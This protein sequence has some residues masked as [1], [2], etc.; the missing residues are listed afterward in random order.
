[1]TPDE[2]IDLL[3][4][5]AS[6]DQRTIGETDIVA[7][8]Q[9]AT[10]CGWTWPLA[11]RAVLEHHKRGGDRPRIKPGHITDAIEAARAQIR[12]QVFQRDLVPPKELADNPRAE[13][14]W[15]RRHIAE[16]TE[17]A[18]NAWAN[19]QPLPQLEAEPNNEPR[20]DVE[21]VIGRVF[22][23]PRERP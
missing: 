16:V 18:L 4:L 12:R 15:R 11:R 22:E 1:M 5:I 3:T 8:H 21:G 20:R 9:I 7:W 6:F 23:M 13:L 14:E 17:R 10:E 2:I 19:G